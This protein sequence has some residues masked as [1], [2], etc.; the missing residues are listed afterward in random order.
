[1]IDD[2]SFGVIPYLVEQDHFLFLLIKHQK[3]HWDF[4]KGHKDG[5]ET[6]L[7]AAS[8]ELKEETGLTP[9]SILE[10]PIF[11]ERY[12]FTDPQK[13]KINKIVYFYLGNVNRAPI[14][15]QDTEVADYGWFEY[16]QALEKITFEQG[17]KI[18]NEAN[19]FLCQKKPD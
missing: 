17:K 16:E 10:Q 2:S 12:K 8:R 4:P 9:I 3:G 14:K 5:D 13:G 15:I 18:L 7:Q 6:D 11:A 1:M 19:H